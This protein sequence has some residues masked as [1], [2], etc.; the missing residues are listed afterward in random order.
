LTLSGIEAILAAGKEDVAKVL[1][2]D[3]ASTISRDT[4]NHY[5]QYARLGDKLLRNFVQFLKVY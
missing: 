2:S 1:G 5:S 3:G 4:V